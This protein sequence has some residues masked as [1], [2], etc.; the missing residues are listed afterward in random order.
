MLHP[1]AQLAQNGFRHIGGVLGDEINPHPL[2]P[3]QPRHLFHLGNQGFGGIGEQQMRL[4]KE[5]HQFRLVGVADLGQL[6]EQFRQ[7]PQ[8]EGGIKPGRGHQLVP[9]QNADAATPFGINRHQVGQLQRRFAEQP[10][11]ALV[12]QHQQTALDGANGGGGDIAIA[13]RHRCGVLADPDQQGLQVFQVQQR[14]PLFIRQTK[15]DVQHPFLRFGQFQQACNQQRP[16]FGNG[17]ADRVALFAEQIPEN[18]RKGAVAII[19][20]ADGGGAF[21]ESLVQ[22]ATFGP[23]HRQPG[24]IALD[25]GQEHRDPRPGKAFGQPLQCHGLAGAGG[26][27][28]QPVPVAELQ[29]QV[30]CNAVGVTPATHEKCICRRHVRSFQAENRGMVRAKI[31]GLPR[32][33]SPLKYI[34]NLYLPV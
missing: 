3:D 9:R 32:E 13:Q 11:P 27:G 4:I 28:D 15:G 30:L 18:H 23:G 33:G 2:G 24:Q 17:G 7:Q 26:P 19:R 12:F 5:E 20:H 6:L 21:G 14:Q 31:R 25:I 22:L 8:Q 1:V 34:V 16:H 10:C 29:Q